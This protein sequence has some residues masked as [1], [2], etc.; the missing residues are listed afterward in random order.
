MAGF[1]AIPIHGGTEQA[2]LRICVLARGA[3][4][5][6]DGSFLLL[7]TTIDALVYLGCVTDTTGAVREWVELWVQS[8]EGLSDG[9]AAAQE[10]FWNQALEERWKNESELLAALEGDRFIHT[11][12]E[13]EHPSPLSI[14]LDSQKADSTASTGPEGWQLCRDDAVLTKAG[15]PSFSRSLH[16]Y[17]W[18][19]GEENP[20]FVPVTSKAPTS[21]QT[22]TAEAAPGGTRTVFNPEAGLL[23]VLRFAP[24]R[25]DEYSDLLSSER[26]ETNLGDK[27]KAVYESLGIIDPEV[28]Q[29]SGALVFGKSKVAGA[30]VAEI[31]H[32]KLQL[33]LDALRKVRTFVERQQLP[34]LNVSPETFRVRLGRVGRGL[35]AFWTAEVSLAKTGNASA[36]NLGDAEARYFVRARETGESIYLP[37]G[38]SRSIV[39]AGVIRVRKL[40]KEARGTVVEGTL[41]PDEPRK[42]SP[43]DLLWLRLPLT[44]QRVDL[45]GHLYATESLASGEVRFVSLPQR[46]A[47]ETEEALRAS[48]GAPFP[49]APFE[50]VP[51]LSSPCDLYSMGVLA[52]RC[53]LVNAQNSLPVALDE[54]LSLAR[55]TSSGGEGGQKLEARVAEAFRSDKRFLSGLGPQRLLREQIEPEAAFTFLPE[56]LWFQALATL[57]RFFPGVNPESYCID[58]GDVPPLALETVFAAPI[59]DLEKMLLRSR[60]LVFINWNENREVNAV[61][62]KIRKAQPKAQA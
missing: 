58:F 34:F 35:P 55:T 43:N 24:F 54:L 17:L 27:N 10:M 32:L 4:H 18:K 8:V 9:L 11:G 59:A 40:S 23:R 14:E 12:W 52:V 6:V 47:K 41:V 39:G 33:L 20:R 48:E 22:A 56:E 2:P 3:P 62:Q 31:F 38:L 13:T 51:V 61:I 16:R 60:S 36:L 37:E 46:F 45:Y 19:P 15:L 1:R 42:F 29:Q 30:K 57:I 5:P 53:L 21:E 49:S 7:R 26:L 28:L 44:G 50:L 25:I